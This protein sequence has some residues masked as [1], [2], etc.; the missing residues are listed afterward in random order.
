MSAEAELKR[1]AERALSFASGDGREAEVVLISDDAQLTRFANNEI[2][3]NVAER[4]VE[5]FVRVAMGRRVG[6]ASGNGVDDDSLRRLVEQATAVAKLQREN[7]DFAGFPGPYLVAAGPIGYSEDTSAATPEERADKVGVICKRALRAGFVAAGA[8]ATSVTETSVAN[9]K[10]TWGFRR[11]THARLLT[12]VSGESSS[13][14]GLRQ[15]VRF[16]ALDAEAVAEEATS[17]AERGRD[18]GEIDP[19]E[20]DVVL[21]PYATEDI[22]RFMSYLGLTG[23]AVV[24]K[25]SFATGKLGERLL[26]EQVTLRDDPLS[27]EGL[28][29]P[30][31]Y[32]GVPKQPL[33]LVEN[34]VVQAVT[35]DSL[36]ASKAGT[37]T[38]G[39]AMLGPYAGYYGPMATNLVLEPGTS[40]REELVRG[41][42]RGLWISRFW[43]TRVVHPLSV[44]VTGMTRDSIFLIEKGEIT[45]PVKSLRFTQ[46]YLSALNQ[47]AGVGNRAH[48]SG[49]A[50]GAPIRAPHLAIRGFTFTG[51]SEY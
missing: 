9:S 35:Y 43:Y 17:K 12:V 11:R 37:Q 46:S 31:D 45:R 34:G 50:L 14:Y 44:T 21:E 19:G 22:V 24:E 4:N 33:T 10:G 32:E 28:P 23:R 18:P 15:G 42:D 5:V 3:Q 40:S 1:A 2:H 30:F 6:T 27:P 36:T 13:G 38:T 41:I 26:G 16:G 20:Y 7:P 47:L 51:K 25:T 48:L 29:L 39:H 8:C 49:D